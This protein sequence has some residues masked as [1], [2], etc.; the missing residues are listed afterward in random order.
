[1]RLGANFR[2]KVAD[3]RNIMK[4]LCSTATGTGLGSTSYKI[5]QCV[6]DRSSENWFICTATAGSGTWI[7][8]NA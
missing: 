1:M 3:G 6:L 2:N 5:G 8:L 7:Q 4:M